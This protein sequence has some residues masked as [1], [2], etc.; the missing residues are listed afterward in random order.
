MKDYAE[1]LRYTNE[2]IAF[3][4]RALRQERR[5]QRSYKRL[6]SVAVNTEGSAWAPPEYGEA[7]SRF[8]DQLYFLIVVLRQVVRGRELMEHFGFPMPQVRQAALIQSWRNIAEHWDDPPKG[9]PVRSMKSWTQESDESHPG[10]S[11][12]GAGGRLRTASGLN[13]RKVRK[14]LRVLRAAIGEVSEAEW[15]H[16]YITEDE[17]AEIL[18]LSTQDFL[19]MSSPPMSM[20][21]EG[22]VGVRYW[23]EWVE[24]RAAGHL[25]PP[26]WL[27]EGWVR[28]H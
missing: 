21:F 3:I 20:D 27:A 10:L 28:F 23:R 17:A 15:H 7:V 6:Q 22:D 5:L 13:V 8:E 24:A 11:H 25:A 1:A 9:I 18:G 14:D 19:S 12:T 4:E 16:C 26:R 2:S